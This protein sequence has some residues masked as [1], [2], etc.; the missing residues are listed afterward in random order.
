MCNRN[1]FSYKG[2]HYSNYAHFSKIISNSKERV[3]FIKQR[4]QNIVLYIKNCRVEPDL[5]VTFSD[6]QPALYFHYLQYLSSCSSWCRIVVVQTFWRT[7]SQESVPFERS[8]KHSMR[9]HFLKN[10]G[11]NFLVSK[12]RGV[13]SAGHSGCDNKKTHHIITKYYA[14]TSASLIIS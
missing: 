13:I 3:K 7:Q 1:F 11:K 4:K 9:L 5:M 2:R 12:F 14:I 8:R 6:T 10:N